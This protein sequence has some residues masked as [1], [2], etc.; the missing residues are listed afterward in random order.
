[1]RRLSFSPISVIYRLHDFI[2]AL[3]VF[4]GKNAYLGGDQGLSAWMVL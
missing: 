4:S 2:T 3:G 1:M